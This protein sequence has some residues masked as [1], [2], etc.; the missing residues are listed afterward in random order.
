MHVLNGAKTDLMKRRKPLERSGARNDGEQ[1]D[2]MLETGLWEGVGG[3]GSAGQRSRK[4]VYTGL[5][6]LW[7]DIS[8]AD[9]QHIELPRV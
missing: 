6:V 9:Q 5:P 2:K 3:K 7:P 1:R 8:G 4:R